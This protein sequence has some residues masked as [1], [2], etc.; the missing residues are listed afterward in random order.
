[1]VEL[2]ALVGNYRLLK[3]HLAPLATLHAAALYLLSWSNVYATLGALAGAAILLIYPVQ[4]VAVFLIILIVLVQVT[5]V[6]RH[7]KS[8]RSVEAQRP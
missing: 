8:R 7:I 4:I 2:T 6:K 5:V 3:S 1:M